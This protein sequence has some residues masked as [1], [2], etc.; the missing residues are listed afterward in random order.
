MA[1]GVKADGELEIELIFLN[2]AEVRIEEFSRRTTPR[3]RV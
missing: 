3:P 1:V 2:D